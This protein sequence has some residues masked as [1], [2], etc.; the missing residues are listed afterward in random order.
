MVKNRQAVFDQA[1]EM[2]A[3]YREKLKEQGTPVA[4]ME[5]TTEE[6]VEG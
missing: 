6:V 3:K 5:I 2:A 4:S 1:E